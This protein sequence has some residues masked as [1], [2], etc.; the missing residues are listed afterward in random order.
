[1]VEFF[2]DE[3]HDR[4]QKSKAVVQTC[5]QDQFDHLLPAHVGLLGVQVLLDVLDVDVAQF[6]EPEVVDRRGH[7]GKEIVLEAGLALFDGVAQPTDDPQVAGL[8]GT[9]EFEFGRRLETLTV[10]D[11]QILRHGKANGVPELVAKSS[12]TLDAEDVQ[13]DI[14]ALIGIGTEGKAKGVGATLRYAMGIVL[15]LALSSA[16]QFLGLEIRRF[17]LRLELLQGNAVH[18]VQW[19][20]DVAQGFGHFPAVSIANESVQIDFGE[21]QTIGEL[22]RHHHHASDPEEENIVAGFQQRGGKEPLEIVGFH[23]P[24]ERRER[25]QTR[26]EPR[27]QHVLV[28][29][30]TDLVLR[31]VESLR[32]FLQGVVHGMRAH[33]VLVI[34]L[35][36]R[37]YIV[38]A[39]EVRRYSMAPPQLP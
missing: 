35:A 3:G 20:D 18:D 4:C 25:K 34:G 2:G 28:L 24:A 6:V 29:L 30:Q 11:V 1:M 32:C 27:V 15:L 16:F 19:I 31:D 10:V 14:S 9:G 17:Q 33:P 26:R 7:L 23:R 36:A 12:V 37:R 8:L 5:V 22:E 38:R 39:D 21:W 13:V